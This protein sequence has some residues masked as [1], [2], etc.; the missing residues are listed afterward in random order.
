MMQ[1]EVIGAGHCPAP[2]PK[3]YVLVRRDLPWPVRCVQATHAVMQLMRDIGYK[4]G[5]GLYGPAVVLLGVK[6]EA[7]LTSWLHRI[8]DN[9]SVPWPAGFREPDLNNQLTAVCYYGQ[10]IEELSELRLM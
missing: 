8:N 3:F 7:E 10:P 2:E 5:W 4:V 1:V 9:D 6:D